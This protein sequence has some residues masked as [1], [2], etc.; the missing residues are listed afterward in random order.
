MIIKFQEYLNSHKK[1]E[2]NYKHN[3]Q[4]RIFECEVKNLIIS[5]SNDQIKEVIDT[6]EDGCL[7]KPSKLSQLIFDLMIWNGK[8][9]FLYILKAT[10]TL[11][12]PQV[13]YI[14][15]DK[16]YEFLIKHKKVKQIRFLWVTNK[17]DLNKTQTDTRI[18]YLTLNTSLN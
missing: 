12:H 9:K 7:I 18:G 10:N 5:F 1:I 14:F 11:D 13:D 6:Y 8:N 4:T 17:S 15:T 16:N 2:C 3:D